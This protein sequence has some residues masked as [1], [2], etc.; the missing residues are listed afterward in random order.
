MLLLGSAPAFS[1]VHLWRVKEI[2]SN[3]DG[4]IQFIELATCCGSTG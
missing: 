4:T 1:G 2:F 3:A